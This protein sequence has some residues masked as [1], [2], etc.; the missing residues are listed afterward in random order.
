MSKSR[1]TKTVIACFLLASTLTHAGAESRL[2]TNLNDGKQQTV[3]TYGTSL[4]ARPGWVSQLREV[5][6]TR[7]PGQA[8]VINSG[9]G[10]KWST[11]G[12]DNLD[13]RVIE[14]KPDTVFIEFAINDADLRRKTSVKQAQDNLENM[15]ERILK[16]NPKC[17]IILMTMNPP[18]GK[19]LELRPR[20]KEYY[21]MYRDVAKAR[22]FLLI[23]HYPEWAKILEN[24][25]D[26]FKKYVP[27]DIHPTREGCKAVTTPNIIKALGI[28][29]EQKNVPDT[30]E[31]G[32]PFPGSK[33]TF[34]GFDM[35]KDN[36]NIIVAPKNVANGKP[37]VW[38]ARF[39]G[40]QPQFD[41][42]M[43]NRG[44]HLVFCNVADLFGSPK[45]VERWNEFYHTLRSEH[46]FAERPVLEGMSRGGLIVYN[47][48]AANPEKVAAIYGDNPV[49]DFKSWPGG[50][51]IGKGEPKSW[52]VCLNAYGLSEQEAMEFP[53]NPVDHLESLAKAG[54]PIIHVIGD[55]DRTVPVAENSRLAEERYKSLGGIFKVINKPNAGHHP[56]SLKDPA[57]IVD[58]VVKH[59]INDKKNPEGLLK[60]SQSILF[61]GDSITQSGTYVVNFEA[62]L[63]KRYPDLRFT[64][65]NAGLSSETVSGLSEENHAGGRF[66]RPCLFERM[67]RVLAKTNPDLIIACYGMNCGIYKELDEERTSQFRNGI[68]RLRAAARE[69]GAEIVHMTPPIYDNHGNV[70]FKYDSVLTTYA[71]WLVEQRE[72]GWHVADL[73]SEMRAKVDQHRK[74]DPG[75]TVQKDRVHPNDEGHWM[76]AQ[77]LIAYFGDSAS[78]QAASAKELLDGSRLNAITQRMRS[79]QDAIHAETKP[80]RPGVRKKGSLGS[81]AAEAKQLEE[82]IYLKKQPETT[83]VEQAA[84]Q[85]QSEGPPSD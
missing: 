34:H 71:E 28:E 33:T 73:H 50:K 26:L 40:H 80:L 17:E 35:Y 37:W 77:C 23:D 45:A 46:G 49:M 84:A 1:F 67:E 62:W 15:I 38:R 41:I 69:Y 12:V 52:E 63:V 16:D 78:A 68:L 20:I 25:P 56:H 7:Y 21:Q 65:I 5:L 74:Q 79:Y 8:N 66:P 18:V 11:W 64:V 47:W 39:W 24:D 76:M 58:F 70:R 61:L 83:K 75:Y 85:L 4:T 57:P 6:N 55:K 27:D 19:H 9:Q 13:G 81:A 43:L 22:D 2:V 54:I 32:A 44:Y 53:Y 30:S 42:E 31:E 51:G 10:A 36:G 60:K 14:K 3:V 29:A 59:S 72:Q 48:A 82:R